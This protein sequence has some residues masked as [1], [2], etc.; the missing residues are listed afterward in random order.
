MFI[1]GIFYTHEMKNHVASEGLDIMKTYDG[2]NALTRDCLN[3]SDNTL[4]RIIIIRYHNAEQVK[5]R[6]S[7]NN[8]VKWAYVRYE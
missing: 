6:K 7:V 2:I 8:C 3:Q 1:L 4:Y 5:N